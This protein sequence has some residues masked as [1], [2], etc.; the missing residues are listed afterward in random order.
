MTITG[1]IM[2]APVYSSNRGS[3]LSLMAMS[4]PVGCSA[5][6]RLVSRPLHWTRFNAAMVRARYWEIAGEP[7]LAAVDTATA[8]V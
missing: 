3:S 2:R 4:S 5:N 1:F 7:K 6:V 8:A